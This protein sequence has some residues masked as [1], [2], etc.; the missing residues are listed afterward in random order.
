[1]ADRIVAEHLTVRDV[2]R[3]GENARKTA[4]AKLSV[5]EA[6]ADT[7]ALQDR[8]GLLFGAK[9]TIRHTGNSGE[10]RIAFQNLDQLEDFCRRL[11][12]D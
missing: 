4:R 8:L 3:L 5:P 11:C 7:L 6:D 2:E 9:V 1:V 10:I 12:R